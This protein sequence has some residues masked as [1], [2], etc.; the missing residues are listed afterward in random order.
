MRRRYHLHPPGLLYLLLV[1]VLGIAAANRPGNLLVWVFAAMLAGVLVSGILSGPT[2]MRLS[3]VRLLPRTARAGEPLVVGYAVSQR[4]RL[5]PAFALHVREREAPPGSRA[6]VAHVGAGETVVA[7]AVFWPDRRGRMVLP[8]FRLETSFP[9]GLIRKSIRF[10]ERGEC[11]VLPRMVRLR[12]DVLPEL[13][14]AGRS[15][16]SSSLRVGPGTDFVGL[17]EYRPGD[18]MR[19]VARPPRP[20]AARGSRTRPTRSPPPGTSPSVRWR[21]RPRSRRWPERRLPT[22][23]ARGRSRRGRCAR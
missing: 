5:W 19:H 13:A 9:F 20:R 1:V 14:G 17:R 3:A 15:G 2:L 16:A 10:D 23:R 22:G 12:A 6:F 11:L 8:S 18:P 21:R 7:E 4:S